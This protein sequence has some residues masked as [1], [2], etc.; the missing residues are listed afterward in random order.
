MM[1]QWLEVFGPIK[2]D[3]ECT[4]LIFRIANGLGLTNKC[5]ISHIFEPRS[6]MDSDFFRHVQIL[7]KTNNIIFM[8]YHGMI[9]EI[10]LPNPGLGIYAIKDYLVGLHPLPLN[11]RS[12]SARLMNT[13]PMHY[14]G[15]DPTP[16]GPGYTTYTDQLGTSR[17]HHPWAP[18]P[19]HH[20][21]GSSQV[22]SEERH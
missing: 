17:Q 4:S 7:K 11:R 3:I 18:S 19:S 16:E 10:P 13:L 12:T 20:S 6:M 22:D 15:V 9:T 1:H 21:S 2:G 8:R 5:I 14:Y